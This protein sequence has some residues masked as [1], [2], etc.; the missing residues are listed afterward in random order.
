MTDTDV[1]RLYAELFN[2]ELYTFDSRA[3]LNFAAALLVGAAG[4]FIV[5]WERGARPAQLYAIF[6]LLF[7]LWAVGRGF[8]LMMNDPEHVLFLSRRLYVLITLAMPLLYQFV[9][10]M[11]RTEKRRMNLIRVQW[12]LGVY[13]A[14]A[15]FMTTSVIVGVERYPWGYE[16]V[17]G[18]LGALSAFWV[19]GMMAAAALDAARAWRESPRGRGERRRITLFCVALI[20]LYPAF[21][22]YLP[23]LGLAVCPTAVVPATLF[24]LMTAYLTWRHGLVQ[25]TPELAAHEIA[26]RVRGAL[27]MLDAEGIVQYANRRC[28]AVLGV[29]E[30][31]LLGRAARA[32]L[33]DTFAPE[34][35]A[36]L[37]RSPDRD[38]EK[39]W[40]HHNPATG[41]PR[42]LAL[43]VFAVKDT[44]QREVAYVCLLRDITEHKRFDLERRSAILRDVLTGLPNRAMLL[45]L[46]DAAIERRRADASHEYAVCFIGLHR[47]RV[48]NEDLGF[49]M[50]DRALLEVVRR[51]RAEV[52]P[53]D[54]V[55]RLGGDEFAVL[56]RGLA[57]REAVLAYADRLRQAIRAPLQLGDHQLHVGASIGLAS[58]ERSYGAGADLLRDAG[59]AMHRARELP[60]GI[61]FVGALGLAG[62]RT[63]LESELRAALQGGQLAVHYQPIVDLGRRRPSGF[64]ALVRW[65]H[66]ARGVLKPDDFLGL[67][68]EAGLMAEIDGF[69][70]REGC[71]GLAQLQRRANDPALS[72]SVNLSEA[73]L[74]R[75][76]SA[77]EVLAAIE[78]ADLDAHDLRVEL[79]ERVVQ[80]DPLQ[81]AL[82]GL[83]ARGIGLYIDDFGTGHSALSRLHEAPVTALKVDRTFVSAMSKG[84]GGEKVIG[85]ILSLARS[86]GI[87]SIAEGACTADEV[88]RLRDAGCRQIQ[89][90]YF[91]QAMPLDGALDWLGGAPALLRDRFAELDGE[92]S[93]ALGPVPA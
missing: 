4:I 41:Q 45:S 13:F 42:D 70:L 84:E 16:P 71:A 20:L 23:G 92:L 59:M 69:V 44:H 88:S 19:A 49:G 65:H 17:F 37:A 2:P 27:L 72:L 31:R 93:D 22:E 33:G 25:V 48:I 67:A 50:G 29:P 3:L 15:S 51:L 75:P 12:A 32:V 81:Q 36:A 82:R 89:G 79:L 62:H 68:E 47:L 55:A 1:P 74:S 60:R 61:E 14:L 86:L 56:I 24:A 10:I 35:L 91:A 40:I 77:A 34:R 83:R 80:L 73:F 64:E 7:L 87:D 53:Q 39:E 9:A 78:R 46:L 6:C 21:T 90:F 30:V 54:A 5:R 76:D 57:A 85:A 18:P 26:D 11:L 63:R 66:P 58:S 52:R 8:A 28:A 43:S 38:A